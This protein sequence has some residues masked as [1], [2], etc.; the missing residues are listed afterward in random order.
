MS[1]LKVSGVVRVDDPTPR[2]RIELAGIAFFDAED[3][4][5]LNDL[6]AL[7]PPA[8]PLFSQAEQNRI[9][10]EFN[11]KRVLEAEQKAARRAADETRLREQ[12]PELADELLPP[13]PEDKQPE[14]HTYVV[15][16]VR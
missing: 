15:G 10:A 13:K 6:M 2:I 9:V 12:F 14:Y 1:H 3:V 5:A 4:A 8:P 11:R 7:P 16:H